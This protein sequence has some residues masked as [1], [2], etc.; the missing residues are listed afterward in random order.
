MP[1]FARWCGSD[2]IDGWHM[3]APGASL[4]GVLRLARECGIL[5]G[6]STGLAL[7]GALAAA[8]RLQSGTVAFIA[9]DGPW[10]YLSTL[11][12]SEP[13]SRRAA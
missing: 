10:K 5:A 1:L 8:A 3:A 7:A 13:Q 11:A 6:P 9:C 12:A 4:A 2:V